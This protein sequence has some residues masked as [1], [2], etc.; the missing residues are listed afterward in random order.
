[1]RPH[2]SKTLEALVKNLLK[3]PHG[4]VPPS[5][6]TAAPTPPTPKAS[7]P[8]QPMRESESNGG[9]L[10]YVAAFVLT[11]ASM[12]LPIE[13]RAPIWL[14]AGAILVH[15]LLFRPS[16]DWIPRRNRWVAV[17]VI[18]LITGWLCLP[19]I[20]S[21]YMEEHAAHTTGE[22]RPS[23][24]FIVPGDTSNNT[25][26]QVGNGGMKLGTQTLGN[27][28]GI[29]PDAIRIRKENGKVLFSTTIRYEAG[30]TVVEIIDNHWRTGSSD[31]CWDKNYNDNALE[32]KDVG[33]RIV[34]QVR[35][36]QDGAQLQGEWRNNHGV[37]VT[38]DDK[39]NSATGII[40]MFKYPSELHWGELSGKYAR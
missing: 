6:P 16:L 38:L 15:V 40:P 34:L 20:E 10:Q 24:D 28:F 35:L 29:G 5:V 18:P 25:W 31:L 23:P 11:F 33:H 36:M 2:K 30:R 1:M 17:F 3:R 22:L 21:T 12:A 37:S 8:K 7:K 13:Y 9:T 27:L 4:L 32:V 14:V 39:V 26:V 19:L